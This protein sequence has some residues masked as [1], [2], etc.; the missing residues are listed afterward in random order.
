M[1]WQHPGFLGLHV[2]SCGVLGPFRWGAFDGFAGFCWCFID[3][4][5]SCVTG[6]HSAFHGTT[7]CR[8]ER[9]SLDHLSLLSWIPCCILLA[10]WHGSCQMSDDVWVYA[11]DIH[12]IPSMVGWSCRHPRLWTETKAFRAAAAEREPMHWGR[13]NGDL[14]CGHPT[15]TPEGRTFLRFP[16]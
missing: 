1:C 9:I 12:D 16:E 8:T 6:Y 4:W 7:R 5:S 11:N 2:R 15:L 10:H 3:G 14:T 13:R